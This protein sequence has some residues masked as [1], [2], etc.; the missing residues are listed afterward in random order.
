MSPS[1]TTN[2]DDENCSSVTGPALVRGD[3]RP[4]HKDAARQT[5]LQG[6]PAGWVAALGWIAA[7]GRSG[8]GRPGS[9][10]AAHESGPRGRGAEGPRAD[11]RER[12]GKEVS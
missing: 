1:I 11:K 8:A 4:E 7:L 9:P 10:F 3:P 2:A 6:S 12:K 5:L